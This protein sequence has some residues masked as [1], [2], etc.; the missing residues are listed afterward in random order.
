MIHSTQLEHD[1]FFR[2]IE[3]VHLLAS[4]SPTWLIM[5]IFFQAFCIEWTESC[6]RGL[7]MLHFRQTAQWT[8]LQQISCGHERLITTCQL[9]IISL[10]FSDHL[11]NKGVAVTE[12]RCTHQWIS[13]RLS[14]RLTHKHNISSKLGVGFSFSSLFLDAINKVPGDQT[15][16]TN[17]L[18][19][20]EKDRF[21]EEVQSW[22][23]I[24]KVVCAGEA[25][26]GRRQSHWALKKW[27]LR[28]RVHGQTY[29]QSLNCLHLFLWMVSIY[30][31]KAHTHTK[32]PNIFFYCVW[33]VYIQSIHSNYIHSNRVLYRQ[34]T[35]Y[36]I[37][38]RINDLVLYCVDN[39]YHDSMLTHHT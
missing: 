39:K 3:A 14:W 34:H 20:S 4:F 7:V 31:D 25:R 29:I 26:C 38:N 5:A 30:M 10:C 8:T 36:N 28:R 2:Q 21:Q 22:C 15:G 16:S 24:H 18:F 37:I 23:W 12:L 33:L 35:M 19:N 32:Y 17:F 27:D 1:F 6:W 11:S 9:S 13:A